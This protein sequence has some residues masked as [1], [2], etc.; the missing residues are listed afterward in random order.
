MIRHAMMLDIAIIGGGL[1]GLSLAQQLLDK[2]GNI[3]VY[4]ARERFGGRILSL[5]EDQSFR[6]DLGPSW[7][8]P[9]LQPRIASFIRQ[10]GIEIYPQWCS[11]ISFYQTDRSQPP[12]AYRDEG[13]YSSARRI[14]GGAY[15]LINVLLQTL[16]PLILKPGHCLREVVDRRDHVELRF[17]CESTQNTIL[18]RRVVLAIPPRVLSNSVLFQP[19]LDERMRTLM[20]A[21]PTWMAGHAKAVIRYQR[22]FWREMGLSGSVRA[23]FQG[24]ALAEIF[25]ASASD[26]T[27][28]ALSGFLALPVELRRQYRDDLQA[29]ILEQL[30]RLFGKEAAQPHDILIK[31]WC[32]E[33]YTAT[34]ADEQIPASH[35]Q[36][37]HPW[38]QLDHW[39]DKLYFSGTETAAEY[40][41]YLEGALEAS[42][43]V[44]NAL[45][46]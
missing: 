27:H 21:T 17:E 46:M 2:Q 28:A 44:M 6:Y 3:A 12:H 37:G 1:S 11:G 13:M 24:A 30:V 41:G 39:S 45:M 7:I 31:D 35:P 36:Y 15:R 38:L 34:T 23:V 9:E 32:D 25:D 40:G 43:R 5:P 8:W 33:T 26:G 18:A 16:P 14:A 22:A 19:A 20:C 29:L 10:H 42:D 4:E